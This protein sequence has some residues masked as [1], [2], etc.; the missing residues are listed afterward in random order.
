MKE[1]KPEEQILTK[2]IYSKN[3]T[4]FSASHFSWEDEFTRA[5]KIEFVDKYKDGILS[6]YLELSDKFEKEKDS[7]PKDAYGSVKT[8]SLKAW[9]NRNDIR[10]AVD[11]T[12]RYGK[13]RHLSERF[14]QHIDCRYNYEVYDDFV[15][16]CFRKTLLSLYDEEKSWLRTH[17]EYYILM[18]K[19]NEKENQFGSLLP[20][21]HSS[22]EDRIQ[23]SSGR[24]SFDGRKFTIPEMKE[25]LEKYDELEK[26]VENL[27]SSFSFTFDNP[28]TE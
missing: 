28:K 13:L 11:N 6:Y 20:L 19:I 25:I 9:L 5:E 7:L 24:E 23:F 22:G 12:Y 18:D 26:F 1:W 15:D 27:K 17:D 3:H 14:I 10:K 4:Y 2:T 21:I 8:V 16:E